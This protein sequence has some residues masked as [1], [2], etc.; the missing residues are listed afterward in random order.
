VPTLAEQYYASCAE[1]LRASDRDRAGVPAIEED[2]ANGT[3][4]YLEVDEWPPEVTAANELVHLGFHVWAR[5]TRVRSRRFW[6]AM[7]KQPR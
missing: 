7:A 4:R 6:M 2:F 3:A 1:L 5:L